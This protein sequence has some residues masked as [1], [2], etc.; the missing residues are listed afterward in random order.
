[1][2][3]K[4]QTASALAGVSADAL[5]VVLAGDALRRSSTNQSPLAPGRHQAGDWQLGQTIALTRPAGLKAS[6]LVLASGQWSGGG[7]A[8]L[9]SALGALKGQQRRTRRSASLSFD[10]GLAESL[11]EQAVLAVAEAVYV[12]RHTK[13]SAR[14]RSSW[15]G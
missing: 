1:M 7:K 12:Y 8:A 10:A 4:I 11:S 13:P 3:F 5:I 14:R 9:T 15:H 2:D 6:R